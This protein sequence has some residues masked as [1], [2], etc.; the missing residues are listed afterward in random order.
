MSLFECAAKFCDR[1][2]I[3]APCG[4]GAQGDYSTRPI[5]REDG[6][7]MKGPNYFRPDIAGALRKS[8]VVLEESAS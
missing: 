8:G 5:Y 4:E 3:D 2:Y 7:V 6:K 1:P